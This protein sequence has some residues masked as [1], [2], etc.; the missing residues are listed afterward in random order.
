MCYQQKATRRAARDQTYDIVSSDA[1]LARIM[2]E[3]ERLDAI[4][5]AEERR[6]RRLRR[7]QVSHNH[8]FIS[9]L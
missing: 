9:L 7:Q 4:R 3:Q 5:R 8:E 6:I 1:R 2:Q